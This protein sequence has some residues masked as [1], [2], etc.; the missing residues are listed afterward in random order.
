MAKTITANIDGKEKPLELRNICKNISGGKRAEIFKNVTSSNAVL[1]RYQEF[2]IKEYCANQDRNYSY[3]HPSALGYCGRKNILDYYSDTKKNID[4]QKYLDYRSIEIF[5][6]GHIVH[7]KFQDKF[8][9]IFSPEAILYG[10]WKCVVCKHVMGREEKLGVVRPSQCEKC[11][12]NGYD[13]I[14]YEEVQVKNDYYNVKGHCDAIVRLSLQHP[15]QVIDFKTCSNYSFNMRVDLNEPVDSHVIQLNTYMWL[16]G[17]DSGYIIYENRD[18]LTHLE[19]SVQRDE[20][21]I[22]RIKNHIDYTNRVI[23]QGLV[24]DPTDENFLI[25]E[26]IGPL[27]NQCRGFMTREGRM[28]PCAY[29]HLCHRETF[30]SEGGSMIYKG[31]VKIQDV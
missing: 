11:G 23:E 17:L 12:A 27:E 22:D 10:C 31:K 4:A 13:D 9:R 2:R 24:P 5:D 18:K 21:L 25:T 3:H 7:G 30:V 29:Y 20:Y 8:S 28:A 6:F 14:L 15:F 26:G 16:L 19:F 1:P